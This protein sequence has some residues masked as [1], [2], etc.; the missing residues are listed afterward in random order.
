MNLL[1]FLTRGAAHA[2]SE[3][4]RKQA[5]IN[6][7]AEDARERWLAALLTD[8]TRAWLNIGEQDR[9]VLSATAIML[10]I[11]G[12]C[13]VYDTKSVDTVDLRIL[14]GGISAAE[15]CGKCG[16]VITRIHAQSLSVACKRA[17]DIIRRATVKAILYAA[18]TIRGTVG[19]A[20]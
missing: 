8:Q 12:F 7:A 2:P 5:S 13:E 9:G 10:T 1:K 3:A 18:E 20:A 19:L 4:E 14:R 6:K 11:A 17:D 16:S 15:Q